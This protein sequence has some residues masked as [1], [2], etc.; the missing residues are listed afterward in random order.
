MKIENPITGE[1]DAK[2]LLDIPSDEIIKIYKDEMGIDVRSYFDGLDNISVYECNKTQYR[3]FYPSITGNEDFYNQLKIQLPRI[4]NT[5]YYCS[6]K[7]EYEIALKNIVLGQKVLEIGCGSGFFLKELMNKGIDATGIELN[8][9]AVQDAKALG[10]KVILSTIEEYSKFDEKYDV[11]CS[12]QVLEHV[13]Q[14]KSF[15]DSC[16]KILNKDGILIISVPNN[17]PFLF[18][19]DLYNVLNLPP[20][21][22]GLWN[23]NSFEGLQSIFKI[24]II[25]LI[26]EKLPKVGY[27]FERYFS[28][29]K[30]LLKPK[31]FLL[32]HFSAFLFFFYIKLFHSHINGKNIVA[33]FKKK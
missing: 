13:Y 8:E 5:P 33:I 28:I 23:K 16:L 15:L 31:I 12:F 24:E 29:N 2:K 27:D 20:H 18:K 19:N 3:F 4:Y 17:E 7:W 10:L 6:W 32:K 21:H 11:I 22:V 30:A 9:I 25:E 26:I 14:V 1:F